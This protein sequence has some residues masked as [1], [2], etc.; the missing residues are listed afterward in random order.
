MGQ[1]RGGYPHGFS[2]SCFYDFLSKNQR[3]EK[4][5]RMTF[6]IV[7]HSDFHALISNFFLVSRPGK[8]QGGELQGNQQISWGVQPPMKTQK[9]LE[10]DF[11]GG[12]HSWDFVCTL[13]HAC[14]SF[15]GGLRGLEKSILK[16]FRGQQKS[17]PDF[18]AGSPPMQR[19][20]DMDVWEVSSP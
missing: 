9:W 5:I 7:K 18:M 8:A 2:S 15:F 10:N 14:R 4:I 1:E 3:V 12:P 6:G 13:A 11:P 19:R 20:A 17:E 16:S